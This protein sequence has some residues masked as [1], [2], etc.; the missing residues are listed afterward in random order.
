MINRFNIS[1]FSFV[2][3]FPNISY[4]NP[5]LRNPGGRISD[6]SS[7]KIKLPANEKVREAMNL[8]IGCIHN[9][10]LGYKKLSLE[11]LVFYLTEVEVRKREGGRGRAQRSERDVEAVTLADET[12]YVSNTLFSQLS[13]GLAVQAYLGRFAGI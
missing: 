6:E 2:L 1:P 4:L 5:K 7:I 12:V 11:L 10:S 8:P 3:P 9:I 13:L